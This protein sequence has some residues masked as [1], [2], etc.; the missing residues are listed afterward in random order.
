ML[1]SDTLSP[2]LPGSAIL[3]PGHLGYSGQRSTWEHCCL[4][5]IP[6]D[7]GEGL[8]DPAFWP[9]QEKRPMSLIA[10]LEGGMRCVF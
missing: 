3:C 10:E 6:V 8:V 1:V 5:F 9:V 2:S 4:L 7:T